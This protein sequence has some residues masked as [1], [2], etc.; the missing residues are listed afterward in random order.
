MSFVMSAH[1]REQWM[2][3]ERWVSVDDGKQ[4]G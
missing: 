3:P 1:E 2:R 4:P